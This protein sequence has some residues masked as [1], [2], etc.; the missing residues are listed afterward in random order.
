MGHLEQTPQYAVDLITFAHP[1]TW[2][3]S[4]LADLATGQWPDAVRLWDR[5]LDLVAASGATGIELTFEPFGWRTGTLAY[6]DAAGLT[7]RL[8][9]RGLAV[10]SGYFVGTET[11]DLLDAHR[12]ADLVRRAGEYAD[13]LLACGADTMVASLPRRLPSGADDSEFVAAVVEG[14]TRVAA[15]VVQRGC[16]FA[17]HTESHSA[18]WTAADID[19]YLALLDPDLV[20]FCPDTAHITL[21]GDDPV[22]VCGKYRDRIALVHWKDA[23]GT[24][25]IDPPDVEDVFA[26]HTPHFRPLGGGEVDLPALIDEFLDAGPLSRVL[27]EVD[28]AVDPVA[29]VRESIATFATMLAR[30]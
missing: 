19:R 3:C 21:A 1:T 9:D 22:A 28:Q 24:L 26:T 16:R 2:S 18:F 27:L 5:L 29:A 17:L 23:A 12:R 4:D 10:T 11:P 7:A 15:A 30:A 8:A 20:G 6:G 25:P 14:I 13:L